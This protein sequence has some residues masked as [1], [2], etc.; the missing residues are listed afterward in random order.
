MPFTRPRLWITTGFAS[1]ARVERLKLVAASTDDQIGGNDSATFRIV[2]PT[3]TTLRTRTPLR[4]FG[5]DGI[6]REYRIRRVLADPRGTWADIEAVPPFMDLAT[7]G[8]VRQIV[9]GTLYTTFAG[10]MSEAQWITNYLLTNLT[11]DGLDWIDPVVGTI[12]EPAEV[13]LSFAQFTR[14]QLW[15][16]LEAAT[17]HEYAL[18]QPS[19]GADYQVVGYTQRNVALPALRVS[20]PGALMRLMVDASDDGLATVVQ[21]LGDVPSGGTEPATIANHVFAVQSI[22]S[23]WVVLIDPAAPSA[24]PIAIDDLVNGLYL[25]FAVGTTVYRRTITDARASDGAVYL[26]DTSNLSVGASV[27]LV[28]D[29][30]GTPITTLAHPAAL[31]LYGRAVVPLPVDGMRG[32]SNLVPNPNFG[33][34]VASWAAR[35]SGWLQL[36]DTAETAHITGALN[37]A[38]GS[39]VTSVPIDGLSA[40]RKIRRGERLEIAAVVLGTTNAVKTIP[41]TLNVTL[42]LAGTLPQ[43][44]TNG[45]SVKQY[46]GGSLVRSL[47]INGNQSAGAS[48]LAVTVVG[49]GT[50]RLTAGDK[51]KFYTGGAY[52]GFSSDS[53]RY[54][55]EFTSDSTWAFTM[56]FH[57]VP[58]PGPGVLPTALSLAIGDTIVINASLVDPPPGGFTGTFT[59]RVASTYSGGST[60]DLEYDGYDGLKLWV[61]YLSTIT[62]TKAATETKSITNSTT[63][64]PDNKQLS[65]TWTGALTISDIWAIEWLDSADGLLGTLLQTGTVSGTSHTVENPATLQIVSGSTIQTQPQNVFAT[66]EVT[67]N[68]SGAVT[69]TTTATAATAPDNATVR[70]PRNTFGWSALG[71]GSGLLLRSSTGFI[72]GATTIVV[73]PAIGS[74]ICWAQFPVS[75]WQSGDDHGTQNATVTLQV[76]NAD[77]NAVIAS[78]VSDAVTLTTPSG[79][80][81]PTPETLTNKVQFEVVNTT[82]VY[83][84]VSVS[85][86]LDFTDTAYLMAHWA[87]I[88][89]GVDPDV[90][91]TPAAFANLG[92]QAAVRYLLAFA[93]DVRT[94]TVTF[95]QLAD[96][97]GAQLVERRAVIG[98]RVVLPTLNET[99]RVVQLTRDH[100]F[101]SRSTVRIAAT[102]KLVSGLTANSS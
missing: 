47:T 65:A 11:E 79:G 52:S 1:G 45:Q 23:G 55:Y 27:R 68:G 85:G 19:E 46:V 44:V 18:V 67:A 38:L 14:A 6:T 77:T 74:V 22:T 26:A 82:R 92:V 102:S 24:L 32:E 80:D 41:S 62:K 16:A 13:T 90:P 35:A 40:G 57:V 95:A 93:K 54:Q 97:V 71:S 87:M 78:V 3:R 31:A 72:T 49:L 73:P 94:V 25:Q 96:I 56:A 61:G 33:L 37:G 51:L 70:I 30:N 21:P 10:T 64:W 63:E 53:V 66:A 58:S 17:G 99:L 28:Q 50:R 100:F 9:N 88:T 2:L 36:Y 60:I 59:A 29:T 34:G 101:P 81:V 76:K 86:T 5:S 98:G 20:T 91:F 8:L 69:A 48:S 12:E 7:S 43:N 75:I 39:G 89:E 42:P 4:F 83:L 15:R 84:E